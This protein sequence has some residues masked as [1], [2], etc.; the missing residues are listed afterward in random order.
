M[1]VLVHNGDSAIVKEKDILFQ[2]F[3]GE[4]LPDDTATKISEDEFQNIMARGG[5]V[6]DISAEIT[7]RAVLLFEEKSKENK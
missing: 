1:K 4:D 2:I 6:D 7:N 3:F 5:W